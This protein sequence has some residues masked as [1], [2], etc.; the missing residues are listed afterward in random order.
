MD[1]SEID[2]RLPE[3]EAKRLFVTLAAVVIRRELNDSQ[4]RELCLAAIHLA[5]RQPA[6]TRD[7]LPAL[8]LDVAAEVTASDR[9]VFP[10]AFTNDREPPLKP[11]RTVPPGLLDDE[12][13]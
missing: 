7:D 3:I 13:H 8:L 4:L 2:F 11:V 9:D 10:R 6:L 5:F 1:K 12:G